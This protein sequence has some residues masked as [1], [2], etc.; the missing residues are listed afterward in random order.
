MALKDFHDIKEN[1]FWENS[2]MM[3]GSERNM[4]WKVPA[5]RGALVLE[6]L[7]CEED[8]LDLATSTVR[9]RG[10]K[11]REHLDTKN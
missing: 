4:E 10:R 8:L 5:V 6:V 2:G 11:V 3:K 9:V 1:D 7:D